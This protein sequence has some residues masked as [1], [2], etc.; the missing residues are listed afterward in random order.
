MM[1][2]YW[3]SH[4][5]GLC[6]RHCRLPE[7]SSENSEGTTLDITYVLHWALCAGSSATERSHTCSPPVLQ[8]SGDLGKTPTNGSPLLEVTGQIQVM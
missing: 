3:G 5:T 7:R 1:D 4:V 8:K 2:I 6:V